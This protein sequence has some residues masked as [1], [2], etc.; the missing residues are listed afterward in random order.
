[1][2]PES[3]TPH[4]TRK[5]AT[6]VLLFT[7]LLT[8][9]SCSKE[10]PVEEVPVVRP[11][12]TM[13]VLSGNA[14][15]QRKLPGTVRAAKRSELSFKVSGPIV[16]LPVDEGQRVKKGAVIAQIQ[17]RDFQTAVNEAKARNLEAEKQF[18]RYKELYARKQVSQA[19]YDSYRA[20]RDIARAQLEDAK[21]RLQDTTLSAPFDGIISKR[22]VEKHQ[23]VRA[24][25]P[26]ANLQDIR[27][28]EILVDIP[29]LMMAAVREDQQV[30]VSASFEA[31]PN[32]TFP[33]T[34][35]EFS[36]QADPATQT[37]QAVLLMDQPQEA[38]I[39][40]GMT[41]TVEANVAKKETDTADSI[42]IPAI[43]ILNDAGNKTFIWV[44]NK[45]SN[46][47]HK[48]NVTVGR[49][50][51]SKNILITEGLQGG[52][53]VITAG[54]TQLEEGMQVRP[55]EKQREGK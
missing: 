38:E 35:K 52:E 23:K 44:L 28:I 3:L 37:Y 11:V 48:R 29:E 16:A 49:L 39:L 43:A 34:L 25:E 45:E 1:M 22:F 5:P 9:T 15:L 18:N 12:K 41:A 2:L 32:K 36:T 27:Q 24:Q 10:E 30:S 33:L 55:W 20:A 17:K 6:I 51:G 40:P 4:H 46:T 14:A 47:A 8:F 42:V 54:V 21:N 31:I 13:E 7:I 50:K 53:T 19:D 26:I